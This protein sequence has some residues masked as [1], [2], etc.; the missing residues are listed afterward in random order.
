MNLCQVLPTSMIHDNTS[1]LFKDLS[2][3]SSHFILTAL[4]PCSG[5]FLSSWSSGPMPGPVLTPADHSGAAPTALCLSSLTR[6]GGRFLRHISALRLGELSQSA[7]QGVRQQLLFSVAAAP[8]SADLVAFGK[9][10]SCSEPGSTSPE[11]CYSSDFPFASCCVSI[12][13][14][15]GL[16][17]TLSP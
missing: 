13:L 11:S 17:H 16:G 6:D 14:S 12:D 10:M 2:Q 4:S 7:G 15:M 8:F 3:P 1:H 5:W 9:I